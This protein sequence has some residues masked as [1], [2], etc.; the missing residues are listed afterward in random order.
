GKSATQVMQEKGMESVDEDEVIQLCQ[1][2]LE[3]NPQVVADVQGGKQQAVGALVG[4]AKQQNSNINP[5]SVR[6]V[7][8]DLIQ[9]MS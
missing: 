9:K 2:L 1:A 4:K 8:L 6:Q 5:G 7:L 3:E